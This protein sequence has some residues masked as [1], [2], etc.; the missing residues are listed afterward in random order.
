MTNEQA[1]LLLLAGGESK[2][3]GRAKHLLLTPYGTMIDHIRK[4]LSPL[5]TEILVVGCGILPAVEE[6]RI[7]EDVLPIHSP[8]VGIYSGLFASQT[9]LCFVLACDMPFVKP[10]LVCH[11]LKSARGVDIAVPVVKGYYE[12]L[13]AAYRKTA[14][15]V[16][17]ET[18]DRGGLKV[19]KIYEHLRLRKVPENELRAFDPKLS[20]FVN[21]NTPRELD[22]LAR[23]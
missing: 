18:L 20:S 22:L 9:D 17:Q 19:T 5:F 13:C 16:I 2:R 4:R 12:P 11:L 15:P 3:M 8:L 6:L 1:T 7:V 10:R 21:L 23:L 14:I